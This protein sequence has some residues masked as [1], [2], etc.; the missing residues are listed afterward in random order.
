MKTFFGVSS[1][2]PNFPSTTERMPQAP[3]N[4]LIAIATL[5]STLCLAAGGVNYND[6]VA[7]ILKKHCAECHGE[8]KRK[9]GLDFSSFETTVKGGSGGPVVVAGRTSKSRLL[10]R[11]L[12]EDA[13]ERMPPNNDPLAAP[14]I[15]LI[16]LWISEGL[17]HNSDSDTRLPKVVEFT[18][19]ADASGEGGPP[20]MPQNLPA[21]AKPKLW[22]PFPVLSLVASPRA[23]L[24]ARASYESID[25][26]D[27]ATQQVIGSVAFAEGEPQVL[28]FSRSGSLLLAA[29]GRPVENGIAALIDVKNGKRLATLGNETD[30]ILAADLSPDERQVAIGG[31]TR[32]VKLIATRDGGRLHSLV[33]HTDW[34]TA[35]AFSPDGSLLVTGDRVGNIY[36]WDSARG[37]LVL[38]LPE[39]KGAIRALVWRPDGKVL[40]SCGEDGLIVWWDVEKG[41]PMTAQADAHM[42]PRA[43]GEYGKISGGVLD[44]AFSRSGQLVTCGR[45]RSVRLWSANGEFVKAF[46][47]RET[48]SQPK[49]HMASIPMR[50][51]ISSDGKQLVAGDSA[52]RLH[53]WVFP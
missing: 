9:A 6:H 12:T 27:P 10:E 13:G 24:L 38:S 2:R 48:A 31:S 33:K 41:L 20:P 1:T 53:T 8:T 3:A 34:V 52:G 14:D 5:G 30:S 25:F 51:T 4:A 7:P 49:E 26:V 42:R 11:L 21:I 15:A 47:M 19:L 40:C 28:R 18:P 45:D 17:R 16:K 39:H 29:G 36:L 46:T 32:I 22:R 43:A 37:Q 50:V 44:A 23:P 35:L